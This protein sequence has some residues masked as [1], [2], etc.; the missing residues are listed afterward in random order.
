MRTAVHL[1]LLSIA[2][3]QV[4]AAAAN[5]TAVFAFG[6]SILDAGN[7]NGLLTIAQAN[8]APYGINFPGRAAT[9]RFSDGKLTSDIIASELGIKA[10]VPAYLD[11]A[12]TDGDLLT[13]VSFASAGSG[14]DAAVTPRVGNVVSLEKQMEYF[15]TAAARMRRSAGEAA[16][17]R[18]IENGLFLI[19][20]GSNDMMINKYILPLRLN[21]SV[22]QYQDFLIQKMDA[23]IRELYSVGAR[24]VAVLGMPPLGCVPLIITWEKI[25]HFH[26]PGSDRTCVDAYNSD[27]EAFNLKLRQLLSDLPPSLG[28]AVKVAYVETYAPAMD[29]INRPAAYGFED[30]VWML[31]I[32]YSGN[33]ES[34]H[35][36]FD[37]V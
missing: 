4:A 23:F 30:T 22:S 16:A 24:R 37:I 8:H 14:L 17:N 26:L 21:F 20:A 7:N 9:G 34:V 35:K 25:K 6:D 1:L 10:A 18:S 36:E 2:A 15:Q 19:S 33:R 5:I 3:V 13:G 27:S 11:P 29:M 28:S 32:W 12:V 31:W